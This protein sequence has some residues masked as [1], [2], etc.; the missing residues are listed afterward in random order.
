MCTG[1][2]LEAKAMRKSTETEIVSRQGSGL[3]LLN[4]N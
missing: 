2:P 4:T 1:F 3:W